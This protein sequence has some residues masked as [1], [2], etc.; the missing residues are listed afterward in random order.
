MSLQQHFEIL[1]VM[2]LKQIIREHNLHTRIMLTQK[3][4][5]LI[6]GLLDHFSGMLPNGDLQSKIYTINTNQQNQP[7]QPQI[8]KTKIT[9]QQIDPAVA[10]LN[11]MLK[12]KTKHSFLVNNDTKAPVVTVFPATMKEK[13]KE[14]A[15]AD[16]LMLTESKL[17][18]ILPDPLTLDQ[19]AKR[20]AAILAKRQLKKPAKEV[21][22]G[23]K[24][25]PYGKLQDKL[26]EDLRTVYNDR[27]VGIIIS[28]F[29]R[30]VIPLNV[31]P[32]RAQIVVDKIM[33]EER[34]EQYERM[35]T[36]TDVQQEIYQQQPKV[37][38][39]KEEEDAY[40]Q[41]RNAQK[42]NRDESSRLFWE[43]R[44]R[45]IEKKKAHRQKRLGK[46]TETITE[47]RRKQ[48]EDKE[49][50]EKAQ[51]EIQMKRAN[52]RPPEV[53]IIMKPETIKRGPKKKQDTTLYGDFER[54]LIRG[55]F[56]SYD[57][58][59][60][61]FR[62]SI[63]GLLKNDTNKVVYNNLKKIYMKVRDILLSTKQEEGNLSE[64]IKLVQFRKLLSKIKP[65]ENIQEEEEEEIIQPQKATAKTKKA[66]GSPDLD[67]VIKSLKIR[68][69]TTQPDAMSKLFNQAYNIMT[70]DFD[71]KNHII[72]TILT[73][74]FKETESELDNYSK[75]SI[76]AFLKSIEPKKDTQLL[77]EKKN[78]IYEVI[79]KYLDDYKKA[80]LKPMKQT[81]II[82]ELQKKI[83]AYEKANDTIV[84]RRSFQEDGSIPPDYLWYVKKKDTRMTGKG[85]LAG[86]GRRR[87]INGKGEHWDR[88]KKIG[89]PILATAAVI[90]ATYAGHKAYQNN[91]SVVSYKGYNPDSHWTPGSYRE[92]TKIEPRS[93]ARIDRGLPSIP[94]IRYPPTAP[95]LPQPLNVIPYTRE[96][97][98]QPRIDLK[99]VIKA[100]KTGD[101]SG[102]TKHQL[103]R[104]NFINRPF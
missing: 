100:Q 95:P 71:L 42:K 27:D 58:L 41:F 89:I 31:D 33:K 29:L 91:N 56:S 38:T 52:K 19:E 23:P 2:Q 98:R 6:K 73:K 85:N 83:A 54:K 53:E 7:N 8:T 69:S 79:D 72:H 18:E 90:G 59:E 39:E 101:I 20:T 57:A 24:L 43:E 64:A 36:G 97:T 4:E 103:D 28:E 75:N 82:E 70:D 67:E 17:R 68:I 3:K 26:R 94:S 63:S 96:L 60:N 12:P 104:F 30:E 11:Q 62:S 65:Q 50:I 81:D 76:T 78:D 13:E 9:E 48:K 21:V 74:V 46:L 1:S 86:D 93:L 92:L 55:N 32:K 61:M 15:R 102:L 37:P 45:K 25:S 88:F 80:F 84:K 10:V 40:R 34:P 16:E 77:F 49:A 35:K 47:V 51:Q 44:E 87:K 99:A 66:T 22:V 14:K 5:G